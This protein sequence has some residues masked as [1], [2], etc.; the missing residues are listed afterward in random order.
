MRR[1]KL[2]GQRLGERNERALGGGV[3]RLARRT[4]LTPHGRYIHDRT[5]LALQ[6]RRQRC[7][8]AVKRAVDVYGEDAPPFIRRDLRNEAVVADAGVVDEH[9]NRANLR[10]RAAH[11]PRICHVAA[12]GARAGLARDYL[13]GFVFFF[14]QKADSIAARGVQTNGGC[15]DAARA[16]GD[17]DV[18]AV[19]SGMF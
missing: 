13:R 2:L 4:D 15:A 7:A 14:I 18:H 19:T 17:D 8:D 11:G 3:R 1:A 12:D 5:R 9:V 10:K 16:A 6:H